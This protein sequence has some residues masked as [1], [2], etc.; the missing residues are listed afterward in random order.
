MEVAVFIK[1]VD[2]ESV[3]IFGPIRDVVEKVFHLF[4][5]LI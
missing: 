2:G 3:S 5:E 1:I 4:I